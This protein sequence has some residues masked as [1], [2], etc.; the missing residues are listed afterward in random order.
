[1]SNYCSVS[2]IR[3]LHALMP[4]DQDAVIEKM[5]DKASAM[6]SSVLRTNFDGHPNSPSIVKSITEEIALFFILKKLYSD[7]TATLPDHINENYIRSLEQLNLILKGRYFV[8][9][10]N[11]NQIKINRR[12]IGSTTSEVKKFF[13]TL[14]DLDWKRTIPSD[15][16]QI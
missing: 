2:D 10:Q 7:N 8:F 14:S 16:Y 13:T 5:I 9:D 15:F 6:V 12:K 11:N 3:L 4:V 1:M